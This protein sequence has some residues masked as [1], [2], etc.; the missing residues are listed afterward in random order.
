M[1]NGPVEQ[2]TTID[3]ETSAERVWNVLREVERWPKRS[4]TVT[5][6]RRLDDGPLARLVL[7]SGWSSPAYPRPSTW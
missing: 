5:S 1:Q 6:V 2:T 4:R 7:G 3:V